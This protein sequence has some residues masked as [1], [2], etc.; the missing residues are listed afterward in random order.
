V[1]DNVITKDYEKF[2]EFISYEDYFCDKMPNL[3]NPYYYISLSMKN[4]KKDNAMR[5]NKVKEVIYF[6]L[7]IG[8]FKSAD[9]QVWRGN[10]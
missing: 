4:N 1:L 7:I 8:V 3:Q 9:Q 5:Y 6:K 2:M 10:A